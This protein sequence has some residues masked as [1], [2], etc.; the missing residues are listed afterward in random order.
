MFCGNSQNGVFSVGDIITLLR[1]AQHK[2][3]LTVITDITWSVC[4]DNEL[5]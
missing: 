3:R 4:H 1:Y 2:M 5:C